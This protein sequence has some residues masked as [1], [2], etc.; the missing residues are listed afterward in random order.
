MLKRAPS[1]TE[2]CRE[3][4][5]GLS[6]LRWRRFGQNA[7]VAQNLHDVL[8]GHVDEDFRCGSLDID[9]ER[10]GDDKLIGSI[11]GQC[12]SHSPGCVGQGE[13]I[14]EMGSVERVE[15]GCLA[16]EVVEEGLSPGEDA[17]EICGADDLR[18]LWSC[19]GEGVSKMGEHGLGI[20]GVAGLFVL[21]EEG[22][23]GV[24]L[25]EH[26]SPCWTVP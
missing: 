26:R 2:T 9:H 17:S 22:C 12:E 16:A 1:Q 6:S 20:A 10:R 23:K 24:V 19:Y 25:R 8:M 5:I 18:S 7:A 21:F 11:V 14:V 15:R 4:G 3:G 13:V